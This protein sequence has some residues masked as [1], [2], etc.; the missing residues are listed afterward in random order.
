MT[1]NFFVENLERSFKLEGFLTKRE[2]GVGYG[3]ADLVLF[4]PHTGNCLKRIRHKQS[5][6]LLHEGYFRVFNSLPDIESHDA[7]MDVQQLHVATAYSSSFLK[8]KLL[9]SIHSLLIQ[10]SH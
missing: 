2:L 8:Y 4:R 5:K 3:V 6:S 1:E 9:D 10:E 7:P